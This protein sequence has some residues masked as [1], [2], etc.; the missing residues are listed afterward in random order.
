MYANTIIVKLK[1][2]FA[3]HGIPEIVNSDNG[4]HFSNYQFKKFAQMWSFEWKT[5]SPRYPQSNGMIE[6]HIGII[7]NLLKKV[8]E[9]NKDQYIALLEYRN[10]PIT[11]DIP[12]PN[13]MLLKRK[14]R[15]ILPTVDNKKDQDL[16]LNIRNK[17]LVRQDI[18]KKNY[19]TNTHVLKPFSLNENVYVRK[20]QNK[21]LVP[22]K[23]V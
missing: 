17:L 6:R 18:Q 21:P 4:T 3:R 22:G 12:S 13:E 20:E 23:I 15:G 7:K 11:N 16:Y 14:V 5:S 19:D 9:D 2:V 10:T 8:E 1:S